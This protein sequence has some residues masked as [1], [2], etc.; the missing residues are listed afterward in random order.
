M[1]ELSAVVLCYRAG[2][3]IG[4][5]IEPLR[6]DLAGA[7]ITYEL[8]LVANF[9]QGSDD[10][11]PD[12]VKAYDGEDVTI[13]SREKA[14]GMGWDM[15]SGLAASSGDFLVVIDG[16]EQNPVDDVLR[17][18]RLMRHSGVDLMKGL[19]VA[20]FDGIYRRVI[21]VAYNFLFRAMFG[22]NGIWDINGKPKGLTRAAYEEMDLRAD[23]WF[24]DAEIVLEALRNRLRIGEMPVVFRRNDA[25]P[26]FVRASA[27]LEFARNMV[28]YRM[29]RWG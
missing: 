17:M 6:N 18:Y 20:R 23:D 25:R 13:V 2:D 21:S 15:R 9:W 10:A 12:A 27:L 8:V 5:V 28:R 11:T 26:S 7:G 22:S 24:I 29:T 3:R 4:R 14:G 19:R 16:D 1:P